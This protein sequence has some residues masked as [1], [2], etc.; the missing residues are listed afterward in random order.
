[1][2]ILW[3]H[4]Q[5]W[6]PLWWELSHTRWHCLHFCL[7]LCLLQPAPQKQHKTI[8]LPLLL[9]TIARTYMYYLVLQFFQVVYHEISH[10]CLV[11]GFTVLF[12]VTFGNFWWNVLAVSICIGFGGKC[13]GQEHHHD[14]PWHTTYLHS[15]EN[16]KG[17]YLSGWLYS[18][19]HGIK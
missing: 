1:M 18:L 19:K 4:S 16:A 11:L 15:T 7:F 5:I 8:I 3:G 6:C 17:F 10:K 9:F 13:E 12:K 2:Y 14:F